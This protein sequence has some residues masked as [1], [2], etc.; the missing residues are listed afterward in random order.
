MDHRTHEIV[1]YER[2]GRTMPDSNGVC[3]N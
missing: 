3:D 2:D 1:E